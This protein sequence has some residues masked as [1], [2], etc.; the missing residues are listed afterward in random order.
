MSITADD[1]RRARSIAEPAAAHILAA[2]RPDKRGGAGLHPRVLVTGMLLSID[3]RGTATIADVHNILTHALPRELQWDLG[4]LGG[5][6]DNPRQVTINQLYKLTQRISTYLDHTEGRAP[7]LNDNQRQARRQTLA[8]IPTDLLANTLIN[9]PDDA[10][11]YA[12]DGTGIWAAERAPAAIPATT[13]EA[14]QVNADLADGT[15]PAPAKAGRGDKGA[16]DAAFGGKTGKDGRTQMYYGYD[17]EALIRIP[18]QRPGN[19][20]RPEPSL[21]EQL[22]VLPASTH[23]TEPC[24]GLIDRIIAS[25]QHIDHLL[26][27]R[28]Y[29]YKQ[30]EQWLSPLLARGIT[31]V[32]DAHANDQGF[33]DWDGMRVAAANFHCPATPD[34]LGVIPTLGPNPTRDERR[35]T[36]ARIDERRAY[37]MQYV[38]RLDAGDRMRVRCPARNGTL[39]CPLVPGT[40]PA[41]ATAGLPVVTPPAEADRPK[42][43]CQDTVTLHLR[44]DAQKT[45][46]KLAQPQYWGSPEWGRNYARRTYIEGWFGVLKSKSSIDCRRGSHQFRGLAL[47]TLVLACAAAVTNMRMLRKWHH[48]TGLGDPTHPLLQPDQEFYGFTQLDVEGARAIDEAHAAQVAEAA[49]SAAAA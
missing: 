49:G 13:D 36:H 38:E 29:S 40:V 21:V 44:T 9:R 48:E 18:N 20:A 33:R 34:H 4:V 6:E 2:I 30:F 35:A 16:S 32:A 47:V 1:Y 5:P 41:A 37:A 43:C 25:G 39:G 31:Q 7:G 12:L 19:T 10:A 27:D 11:D 8:G 45:A 46:M 14:T 42:V 17:C 26:V 24:L 22:V 28:H 15:A 23:I 3:A